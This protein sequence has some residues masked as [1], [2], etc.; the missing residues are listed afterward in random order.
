M[1]RLSI[2]GIGEGLRRMQRRTFTFGASSG[3]PDVTITT[4]TGTTALIDINEANVFVKSIEYQVLEAISVSGAGGLTLGDGDDVDGYWT[5][6][7]FN[8]YATDAGFENMATSVAYSGGKLYTA[9]DSIDL[10]K[11]VARA[12]GGKVKVRVNYFRNADTNLNP[13][14]ST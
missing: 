13:A 2:P 12:A 11:T 10:T 6:T 8:G 9:S 3:S 4:G 7:L 5:D 1:A 14:A